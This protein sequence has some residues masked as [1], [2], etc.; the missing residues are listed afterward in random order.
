MTERGDRTFSRRGFAQAMAGGSLI[1]GFDAM[2]G[3]WVSAADAHG[4]PFA[5][6]PHLDGELSF[7]PATRNE[8]AKDYGQIIHEQPIAVLRPG[9]VDDISRMIAFARRFGLK[10]AARGEGHQP[11]GQAQVCGGIVIDMRSLQQIHTFPADSVEVDAGASWRTVLQST[12]SHGLAPPVLTKF[13]GLTVGGTLSI[14]GV[15]V[16]SL[17]HG[18][19]IDQTLALQVVTG[20]G[21]LVTCS[22]QHQRDL[23]GAVLAGQGKFAVITRATLRLERAPRQ[24]REYV[25]PYRDLA[26]LVQD[27]TR[28]T[29]DG[30]F[31]GA[32]A[33]IMSMDGKWSYALA[34]V[35]HFTTPDTPN[36][37]ALLDGLQFLRGAE[38]IRD[39]GY[40][41]YLDEMPPIDFTQ[42]HADLGLLM[43]QPQATSFIGNALPRL[44]PDD[45]GAVQG[46]R[47]F[48]WK[49]DVFARPLL[50][51]PD[52]RL[53]CYAALLRAPPS[54]AES[55]ARTL[56]G[57]R[58]LYD[59]NRSGG[60]TLYPFAAIE[61][62][63]DDW[64]RHYGAQW[65]AI[66]QAKRRYD[67]DAVLASGPNFYFT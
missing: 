5:S 40:F 66:E 17:R 35:K 28:V 45:L 13:L 30:R 18:A 55:L 33:L 43:P 21:D 26:T 16:A 64:R 14:G 2:T 53:V 36:D 1:V 22:A 6:V 51:L 3:S 4:S 65:H 37:A 10:I 54:D 27:G 23:F 32:V 24:V 63:R 44:T 58:T 48:F 41:E 62:M 29:L 9:S 47:L 31:D 7:D 60:G 39:V 59:L 61:L 38:K 15:G 52:D 46:I 49:R 50:R 42:A 19:Q 57:N 11:F 25:L 34:P 20:E 8:Y 67:P 12:L 56:S